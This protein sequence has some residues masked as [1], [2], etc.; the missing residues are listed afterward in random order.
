MFRS[1]SEK[2]YGLWII[3]LVFS[4]LIGFIFS[5]LENS[6]HKSAFLSKGD[7]FEI[8]I[9][10]SGK[11]Y[12]NV[13]ISDI[14]GNWL[15]IEYSRRE[16]LQEN[17]ENCKQESIQAMQKNYRETSGGTIEF[18]FSNPG[19][20]TAYLRDKYGNR[21]VRV[22]ET[23]SSTFLPADKVEKAK[24]DCQDNS[25]V[26]VPIFI[27]INVNEI[28]EVISVAETTNSNN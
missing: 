19:N 8:I 23:F 20:S 15:E 27:K 22:G 18:D 6:S 24:S 7:I 16:F 14:K 17:F 2:I 10:E 21:L 28:S 1:T 9:L 11:K 5:L 13:T 25:Y 3:F 26:K 12:R 4:S